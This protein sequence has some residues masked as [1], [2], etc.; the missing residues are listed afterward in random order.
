LLSGGR[1]E[2]LLARGRLAMGAMVGVFGAMMVA[3]VAAPAHDHGHTG[4]FAAGHPHAGEAKG[5]HHDG[6]AAHRQGEADHH[7]G[8]AHPAHGPEEALHEHTRAL[9][10]AHLHR[11]GR[12][13]SATH[14]A[15]RHHPDVHAAGAT[16]H[17]HGPGSTEAGHGHGSGPVGSHD[18]GHGDQAGHH[19]EGGRDEHGGHDDDHGGANPVDTLMTFIDE[20]S[21]RLDR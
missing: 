21:K 4:E 7:A 19:G 11:D 12:R 15:H 18:Q 16:A 1:R 5:D 8:A 20:A 6:D 3:G 10:P 2:R 14:G 13:G 17:D 9:G